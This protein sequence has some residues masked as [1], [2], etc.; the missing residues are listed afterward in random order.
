[1]NSTPFVLDEGDE[2]RIREK[3]DKEVLFYLNSENSLMREAEVAT[4]EGRIQDAVMLLRAV[5]TI[6]I[7]NQEAK[8][9]IYEVASSQT[10]EDFR[11]RRLDK[12]SQ[13]AEVYRHD[14]ISN[15]LDNNTIYSFYLRVKDNL[16]LI[17]YVFGTKIS[18]MFPIYTKIIGLCEIGRIDL[19][20]FRRWKGKGLGEHMTAL[21]IG[22]Y[23]FPFALASNTLELYFYTYEY[24]IINIESD[25]VLEDV[26]GTRIEGKIFRGYTEHTVFD[27]QKYL[28]FSISEEKM[29]LVVNII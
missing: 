28:P 4:N 19:T 18:T 20:K 29:P 24:P 3:F 12:V 22:D 26:D 8:S 21:R 16:I 7:D 27:L 13:L 11:T 14:V 5:L 17:R 6:N 9:K 25:I 23:L 2:R 15:L 10:R 1:M